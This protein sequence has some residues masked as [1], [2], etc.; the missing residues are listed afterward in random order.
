[1]IYHLKLILEIKYKILLIIHIILNLIFL[2]I[3]KK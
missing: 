3:L 2:S 1:M